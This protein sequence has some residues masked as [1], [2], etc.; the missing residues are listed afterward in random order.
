[1]NFISFIAGICVATGAC[2]EIGGTFWGAFCF[3]LCLMFGGTLGL[4]RFLDDRRNEVFHRI[5]A[6]LEKKG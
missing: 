2:Y 5:A 1:M 3:G 4:W 6:A